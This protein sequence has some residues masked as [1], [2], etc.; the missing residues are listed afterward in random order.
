MTTQTPPLSITIGTHIPQP[1][2]H[3]SNT[4]AGDNSENHMTGISGDDVFSNNR[5]V[6][7]GDQLPINGIPNVKS[8]DSDHDE[9]HNLVNAI[10]MQ[11]SSTQRQ[12]DGSHSKVQPPNPFKGTDSAKLHTSLIRPQT[13]LSNQD[14]KQSAPRKTSSSSQRSDKRTLDLGNKLGKDG[15]LTPVEQ[16]DGWR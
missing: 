9:Q 3:N 11:T 13:S 4:T 1:S 2:K 16:R 10:S 8:D 15:K 5:N 7:P 6:D 12:G 14:E